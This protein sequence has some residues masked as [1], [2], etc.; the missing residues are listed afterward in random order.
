MTR[1]APYSLSHRYQGPNRHV[2]F[3]A[4]NVSSVVPFR[5]QD[6]GRKARGTSAV[7]GLE[8][9]V[10]DPGGEHYNV[11]GTGFV[12]GSRRRTGR[13]DFSPRVVC[14]CLKRRWEYVDC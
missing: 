9:R 12:I 5:R 8:G 7:A 4:A 6:R 14:P 10:A 2:F 3:L 1:D 13:L 11:P